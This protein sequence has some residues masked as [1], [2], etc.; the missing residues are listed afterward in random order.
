[1]FASVEV[2]VQH[3]FW[4]GRGRGRRH[5]NRTIV[6]TT[7][8]NRTIVYTTEHNMCLITL[9]NYVNI[10]ICLFTIVL[11][12]IHSYAMIRNGIPHADG[13]VI[14]HLSALEGFLS[15][16]LYFRSRLS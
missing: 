6:Y 11:S 2:Q 3:F 13:G 9:S 8:H 15:A 14:L 16:G 7:E 10:N 1:M 5:S 4:R 12:F